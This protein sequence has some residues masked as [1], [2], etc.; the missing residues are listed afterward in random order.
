M[1]PPT[2]A[3]LFFDLAITNQRVALNR[4]RGGIGKHADNLARWIPGAFLLSVFAPR[5]TPNRLRA[6]SS[7]PLQLPAGAQSVVPSRERSYIEQNVAY[8]EASEREVNVD[9]VG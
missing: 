5:L 2:L 3:I 7:F 8:S 9:I 6:F 1:T 4:I